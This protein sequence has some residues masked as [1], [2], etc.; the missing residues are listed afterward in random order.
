MAW[1]AAQLRPDVIAAKAQL[2]AA[3]Q[4]LA[5]ANTNAAQKPPGELDAAQAALLALLKPETDGIR[6]S[7]R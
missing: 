2:Q 5:A 7:F 1:Q 6:R 4:A 3:S